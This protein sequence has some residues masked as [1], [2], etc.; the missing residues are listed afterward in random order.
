MND[1]YGQ[2]LKGRRGMSAFDSQADR[3]YRQ[4]EAAMQAW[5]DI[6]MPDMDGYEVCRQLKADPATSDI[7]LIC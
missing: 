5:L 7:P 6:M 1:V 2:I 3:G 4:G